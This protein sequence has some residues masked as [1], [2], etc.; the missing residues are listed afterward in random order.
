MLYPPS[1]FPSDV[2]VLDDVEDKIES[3]PKTN[4]D[5]APPPP[6][7]GYDYQWYQRNKA[8][9]ASMKNDM[10]LLSDFTI[11]ATEKGDTVQSFKTR[12]KRSQMSK[13]EL[14]H[15]KEEISKT[16][17]TVQI[18]TTKDG[19]VEVC[20]QSLTASH[21]KAAIVSLQIMED[22]ERKKEVD[23]EMKAKSHLSMVEG[24]TRNMIRKVDQILRT[25]DYAKEQEY[26]FHQQSLAMNRASHYWPMIH[27]A[28]LIITGFT[29]AHHMV[30]FF[31]AR[32]I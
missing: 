6:G 27:V 25:A 9:L 12:F 19:I 28:V 8:R 26:E 15:I 24:N 7:S 14:A 5:T 4:N 32:H 21:T 18:E 10:G 29:F 16:T 22:Q 2:I 13:K 1:L 31:K 20:V 17:G 30:A 3:T 11:T 23:L